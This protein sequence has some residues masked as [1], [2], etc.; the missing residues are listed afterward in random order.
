[1][2]PINTVSAILKAKDGRFLLQLRD[3]NPKIRYRDCWTN[4][5]GYIEPGESPEQCVRRELQEEI[6]FI[7][8]QVSLWKV[9]PWKE[10]LIHIFE[11]Q[12]DR[13]IKELTL[14]EGADMRFFTKEEILDTDLAFCFN[15][16]YIDYFDERV[17]KRGVAAILRVKDGRILLQRRDDIPTIP[18]PGEWT[19]FGGGLEPK[20]APIDGLKREL[21]EE[22]EFEPKDFKLWKVKFVNGYLAHIFEVQLDQEICSL[23]QHEGM[24][25]RL[26]SPGEILMMDLAFGYTS[27]LARY[28]KCQDST[29]L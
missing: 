25:M 29:S 16:V 14:T 28:F 12:I 21:Q 13:G 27:V 26:F 4:F 15:E 23:R 8:Q 7:P 3:D 24:D 11:I 10:Y 5:G 9:L 17:E 6:G 1:M 2:T 22:L 20:E 18:C 19:L